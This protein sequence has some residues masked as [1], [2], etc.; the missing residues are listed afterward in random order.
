MTKQ[1]VREFVTEYNQK[2]KWPADDDGDL[3]ETL[4]DGSDHVKTVQHE[5]HRW[6]IRA[7]TVVKLD[8]KYIKFDDYVTTGDSGVQDLGLE[9]DL[10][11]ARFV[12]RKERQIT[13]I[14]YE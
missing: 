9:Y 13:E 1:T 12:E 11:S 6:Y 3:M 4:L 2:N 10:D 14:Y 8:G 7:E 5:A